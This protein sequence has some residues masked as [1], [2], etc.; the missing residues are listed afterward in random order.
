MLKAPA[1]G[2]GIV[3]RLEHQGNTVG[4]LQKRRVFS[5]PTDCHQI[6]TLAA[7][8]DAVP[9]FPP[10]PP[11]D[12]RISTNGSVAL[13]SCAVHR[14][15]QRIGKGQQAVE[16]THILLTQSPPPSALDPQISCSQSP[17]PSVH[18]THKYHSHRP[19]HLQ[20]LGCRGCHCEFW[21]T[22][23]PG[24]VKGPPQF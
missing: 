22:R 23:R 12:G 2:N 14:Q 7:P 18:R 1:S 16:P 19:P 9:S 20:C 4:C 5:R 6:T 15:P 8:C 11:S 17:P 10:A 24:P 21:G 13:E 3:L